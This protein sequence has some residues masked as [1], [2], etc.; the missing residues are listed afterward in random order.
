[1]GKWYKNVGAEVFNPR[2]NSILKSMEKLEHLFQPIVAEAE[3]EL[4]KA[5]G[6]LFTGP[7]VRNYLPQ[8]WVFVTEEETIS[9]TVDRNG[10]VKTVAGAPNPPD[11]IIQSDHAYLSEALRTRSKPK[12]G[13]KV[14]EIKFKTSK[15][16]TAFGFLRKRLGL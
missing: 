5:L 6:N 8:A 1:M 15:G 12:S 14:W 13:P 10:N 3:I 11:V 7:I 9:F 4:K 2:G 16:E